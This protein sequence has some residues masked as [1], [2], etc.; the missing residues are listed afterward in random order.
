MVELAM[1]EGL[2]GKSREQQAELLTSIGPHLEA[3]QRMAPLITEALLAKM[4]SETGYEAN[5]CA[6]LNTDKVI[7]KHLGIAVSAIAAWRRIEGRALADQTRAAAEAERNARLGYAGEVGDQVRLTGTVT[8]SLRLD[9]YKWNSPQQAM[10]VVD[11]GTS[12]AKIITTAAWAY[13]VKLGDTLTVAATVKAHDEY[14]G[15]PQTVLLRPKKLDNPPALNSAG[16]EAEPKWETVKPVSPQAR[17][18]ETPMAASSPVA[19][20]LSV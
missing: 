14:R 5:L 12:I 18:Q 9:G 17:F 16:K 2:S 3:G 19:R 4:T 20:S 1:A 15:A 11:C 6:L 8:T 13:E 10:L 7:R